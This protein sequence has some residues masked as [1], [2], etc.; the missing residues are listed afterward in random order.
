MRLAAPGGQG[1]LAIPGSFGSTDSDLL[2][3]DYLTRIPLI[4]THLIRTHSIRLAAALAASV[5]FQYQR[6]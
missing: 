6:P 1:T 5:R 3:P 2:D 4:R